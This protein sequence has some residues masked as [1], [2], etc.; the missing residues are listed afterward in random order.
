MKRI[1]MLVLLLIPTVAYCAGDVLLGADKNK[2]P[3]TDF[4][5][6][7]N[8]FGGMVLITPDADWQTKWETAPDTVPR[9]SEAATV[10][11]GQE[12]V[13]LSFFVNPR[14]DEK[15]NAHVTCGLRV[16]RPNGTISAEQHGIECLNGKL[17]GSPDYI[18]L[19]P[20]VIKF[21]GDK[22]DPIGKWLVEIEIEDV[23]RSTKLELKTH[24]ELVP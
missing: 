2:W 19:T 16:I 18:R 15:G 7:R 12:V 5:M 9:F 11:V 14:V 10:K 22:N 21:V 20:A 24:F 23:N 4:R 17:E 1:L 6:V 13:V 3:E 8:D